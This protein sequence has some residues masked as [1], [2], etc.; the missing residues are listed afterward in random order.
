MDPPITR[1]GLA[2]A[3]A[4]ALTVAIAVPSVA[5]AS[6]APLPAAQKNPAVQ[7]NDV[8][9]AALQVDRMGRER[10]PDVYAG[11]ELRERRIVVFRVPSPAFDDELRRLDLRVPAELVDA[12]YS[13]RALESL[14]ARVVAD[15]GFWKAQGIEIMSVG[16]RPDGTAVQVGTPQAPRLAP[17]LP[18]RY[19]TDPPAVAEQIGPV[20]AA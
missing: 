4:L 3:C 15:I 1:A 17:L 18:G 7:E 12:P 19:G 13:G 2:T 10:F 20:T 8:D 5:L 9:D 11:V 16:A 6:S 14:A